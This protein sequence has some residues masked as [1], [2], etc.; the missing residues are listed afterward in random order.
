MI[1]AGTMNDNEIIV[2]KGLTKDDVVYLSPPADTS[3][4]R[5]EKI[6][7]LRPK[8][9]APDKPATPTPDTGRSVTVPVKPA[10]AAPMPP[11]GFTPIAKPKS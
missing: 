3:G 7:G 1:D 2:R 5:T 9:A 4:I 10:G 11:T 8:S 6:E